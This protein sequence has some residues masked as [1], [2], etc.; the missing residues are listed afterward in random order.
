MK[1]TINP[2]PRLSYNLVNSI[3]PTQLQITWDSQQKTH[4]VANFFGGNVRHLVMYDMGFR[5]SWMNAS[6]FKQKH[7][8]RTSSNV[9]L[10]RFPPSS[11]GRSIDQDVLLHCCKLIFPRMFSKASID[12]YPMETGRKKGEQWTY[13][14]R[15]LGST[16]ST[17]HF[18]RNRITGSRWRSIWHQSGESKRNNWDPKSTCSPTWL[19]SKKTV[20]YSKKPAS[21]AP[22]WETSPYITS[23]T[24]PILS[25]SLL[26]FT[27]ICGT[28]MYHKYMV[29]SNLRI[30]VR[31]RVNFGGAASTASCNVGASD[32]VTNVLRMLWQGNHSDSNTRFR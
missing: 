15:I 29:G 17:S 5:A 24:K 4:T 25:N 6:W 11:K 28:K 3:Q 27:T 12:R 9:M 16:C 32:L 21:K 26:I 23:L 13:H 2:G 1:I 19:R 8:K 20:V 14:C 10:E 31:P 18:Q 7:P 30:Q 22:I